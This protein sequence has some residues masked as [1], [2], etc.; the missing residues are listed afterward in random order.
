[1]DKTTW[2]KEIKHKIIYS[3]YSNLY[4][5]QEQAKLIFSVRREMAVN[6]RRLKASG[7]LVMIYSLNWMM[8]TWMCHFV[9]FAKVYIYDFY[10]FLY[11]MPKQNLQK[12]ERVEKYDNYTYA[13]VCLPM[14]QS[15]VVP[16]RRLTGGQ[17][18]FHRTAFPW[19][20]YKNPI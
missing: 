13:G 6:E 11:V 4:K 9:N 3:I 5:V 19:Y 7:M 18:R 16:K 1:M 12:W 10:T 8:V 2:V 17:S 15:K 20:T 14:V